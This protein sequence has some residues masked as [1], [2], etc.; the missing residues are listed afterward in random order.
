MQP[1][2]GSAPPESP[3]PAPRGTTGSPASRAMRTTWQTSAVEPG[4]TT[5]PGRARKLA[6]PSHS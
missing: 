4:S 5:T 6:S 3:V 1:G 2:T